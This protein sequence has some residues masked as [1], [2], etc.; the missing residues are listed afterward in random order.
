MS[1]LSGDV[2]SSGGVTSDLALHLIEHEFRVPVL[3][4]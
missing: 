1:V 2:L 4:R 3:S